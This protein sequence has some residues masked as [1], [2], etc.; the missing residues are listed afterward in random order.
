MKTTISKSLLFIALLVVTLGACKDRNAEKRIAELESEL[1]KMKGQQEPKPI[2]AE[3]AE[4]KP[5][6]P[7]PEFAFATTKHDFGTL[8]EGA[9]AEFT[10]NFKNSGAVP[11]VISAVRPSCGCTVPEYSKEPIPAGETGFVKVK[12][13]TNGK[14]N[15]QNKTVTVVANTFP[16]ET[17]L[18]FTALIVPKGDAAK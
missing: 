13:D 8:K 5:D 10:Y 6:G 9:P 4:Q 2:A 18:S 1:Q 16:K 17:I 14:S 15:V 7:L 11:L 3:P 12:F